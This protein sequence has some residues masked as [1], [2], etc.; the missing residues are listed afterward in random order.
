ML[1]VNFIMYGQT[2]YYIFQFSCWNFTVFY[3]SYEYL[4]IMYNYFKLFQT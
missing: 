3:S 1:I 2:Y 4:Q